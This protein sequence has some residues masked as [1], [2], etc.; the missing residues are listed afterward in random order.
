MSNPFAQAPILLLKILILKIELLGNLAFRFLSLILPLRPKKDIT[1]DVVLVTGAASGIGQLMAYKFAKQGAK[2]IVCWD[3]NQS[4][5]DATVKNIKANGGKAIGLTCNLADMDDTYRAVEE[6]KK[7]LK[8]TLNDDKAYVS[9]LVNNA[10]VVTGRTFLDCPDKLI[11]LTMDVNTTAHFWTIKGFLP[12]MIKYNKGHVCTIASGAGLSGMAGLMDYCASKFGA[13]GLSESLYFEMTKQ[14][15]NINITTI[16]PYF[17]STGM[18]EGVSN[19]YPWLL[20]I[21]KPNAMADEIVSAVRMN[22]EMI[23]HPKILWILFYMKP[24]LGLKFT[25]KAMELLKLE[26]SM[27]RFVQTRDLNKKM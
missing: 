24:L 25:Y 21:I 7:L 13:V 15:K 3:L 8:K 5:N 17:I 11:K 10:G 14:G 26:K 23:I 18:F 27:D 12:D 1:N 16:C 6:T 9:I 22:K 4:G 19:Y 2:L 20:P